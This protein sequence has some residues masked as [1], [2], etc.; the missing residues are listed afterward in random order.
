LGS[1]G[2]S[3]LSISHGSKLL[4]PATVDVKIVMYK[5][6]IGSQLFQARV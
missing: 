4:T 5:T 3:I 2:I 1:K 6:K